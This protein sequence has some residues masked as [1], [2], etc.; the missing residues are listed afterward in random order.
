LVVLA[1]I[2]VVALSLWVHATLAGPQA[3]HAEALR[4]MGSFI[5]WT[6]PFI[7]LAA[8]M[9]AGYS[10]PRG[11]AM[12]SP[13]VGLVLASFGWLLTRKVDLLPPDPNAVGFMLTAG[14]LFALVGSLVS[15][16]LR[17]HTPGVVAA[18]AGLGLLAWL[19]AY[20]NLGAVPGHCQQEVTQRADGMTTAMTTEPVPGVRVA[21]LDPKDH[22]ERYVTVSDDRGKFYFQRLPLGQYVLTAIYDGPTGRTVI[23]KEIAVQRTIEG[24]TPP[25]TIALPGVVKEAGRIFE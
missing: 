5:Y 4:R 9:L 6:Q 14:A 3:T 22:T 12:R 15:G 18:M 11:A 23:N 25:E 10:M 19:G 1:G 17:S 16:L 7:Y 24:G 13:V 20:L 21:L 8:G 2:A